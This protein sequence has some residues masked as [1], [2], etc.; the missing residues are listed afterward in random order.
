MSISLL[1]VPVRSHTTVN[2][3]VARDHTQITIQPRKQQ[4]GD[5]LMGMRPLCFR[6]PFFVARY[7]KPLD[8]FSNKRWL[9]CL[10]FT[11]SMTGA[12]SYKVPSDKT[13]LSISVIHRGE[14]RHFSFINRKGR[15][16]LVIIQTRTSKETIRTG[17]I[18]KDKLAFSILSN[19]HYVNTIHNL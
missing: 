4:P 7:R 3:R 14:S 1:G 13:T 9:I 5:H 10:I 11:H 17:Q 15:N 16:S 8:Y 2:C 6:Y 12:N 18:H 19:Y